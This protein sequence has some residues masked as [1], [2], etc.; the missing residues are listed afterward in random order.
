M[1]SSKKLSVDKMSENLAENHSCSS[2]QS[3]GE[4]TPKV[5]VIV[6]VYKVEKYLPECIDSILAQTFTDFEL[7][8]VDDGSP[9]NSGKIC[10]DYAARDF[11]IRVF[12]KENGGVSSARNLGIKNARADYI[13]F[14]DSDDWWKPEFLEKMVTLARKYPQAGCCCCCWMTFSTQ[15]GE[16]IPSLFPDKERGDMC[17]I[18]MLS[19]SAGKGHFPI[20][21]GAVLLKKNILTGIG[22]FD[23]NLMASE[24]Y[25]VWFEFV[26]RAPV[27][28]LNDAFAYYRKDVPAENKPRWTS[29]RKRTNI[30]RHWVSHLDQYRELERTN[31]TVKLFLDRFRLYCLL[32]YRN[33]LSCKDTF[34]R[35]YRE[36]DRKSFTWQYRIAYFV[37]PIVGK[38][39]SKAYLVLSRVAHRVLAHV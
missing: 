36:I 20:W 1:N 25:K 9:D 38:I 21:T 2:V 7:I 37:P 28:Y 17:L 32:A 39:L 23:E 22:G 13:A 15:A 8:L 29:G 4:K 33:D 3:V 27:A 31:P 10:D 6:P 34:L 5:S 24:D 19:Y 35:V 14:L 30:E 16:S 18:D 26:L 12:H 11:R